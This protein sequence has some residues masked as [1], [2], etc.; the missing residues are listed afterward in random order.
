MIRLLL[1][2]YQKKKTAENL[3]IWTVPTTDRQDD[4]H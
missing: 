3:N 4:T 2:C 1:L